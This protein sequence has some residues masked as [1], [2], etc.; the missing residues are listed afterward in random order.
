[1]ICLILNIQLY[2]SGQLIPR[3]FFGK[4]FGGGGSGV[5]I[6]NEVVVGGGAA[7]VDGVVV[8]W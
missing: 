8:D 5:S 4:R 3:N 6:R 1:M 7:V 2:T